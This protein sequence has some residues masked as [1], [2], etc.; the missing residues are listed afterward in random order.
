MSILPGENGTVSA[1]T[2]ADG[3]IVAVGWTAGSR[4]TAMAW[5]TSD[6]RTWHATELP[7]SAG[8][9]AY[10][11]AV[12]P[13][14]FLAWGLGDTSTEFWVST[15]G[16]NWRSLATSGLPESV[17]DELYAVP[18]SY[19]IRGFLSDRAAV[20]RSDNGSHW[21]Q[22]WTGPGPSGLEFY[23]MGPIAR[24]TDG[25]YAS[26]GCACMGPGGAPSVPYD[27]IVWTSSDLTSWT[28]SARIPAPGWI[29]G[30]AAVPGGFVAAGAQPPEGEGGLDLSGPLRVWTSADGRTWQP[31]DTP[32]TGPIEVLS[33]V[34]DGA[35]AIV[36]FVAKDGLV[37]MLVGTGLR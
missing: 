20:W 4:D 34:S 9:R 22:A 28:R 11:I 10:G 3:L 5:S 31:L 2:E 18:G 8:T 36:S 33:V 26:F 29:N 27:V 35:H 30:F 17:I 16:A 37:S 14:G 7:A 15:D 13:A 19:V 25:S 6:L 24:A 21:T 23:G 32:S 12:G 1:V